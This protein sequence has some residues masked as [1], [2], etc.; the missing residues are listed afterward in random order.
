[1][2]NVTIQTGSESF[3]KSVKLLKYQAYSLICLSASTMHDSPSPEHPGRVPED[4][5]PVDVAQAR[6]VHGRVIR[7]PARVRDDHRVHD[8]RQP[9]V[10]D[11][12]LQV[13]GTKVTIYERIM[14]QLL[15]WMNRDMTR[16]QQDRYM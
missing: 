3:R 8:R 15:I 14:L 2:I 5:G 13:L 1:M 7:R 12:L 11:R 10:Y 16:Q 4:S 9:L 6:A